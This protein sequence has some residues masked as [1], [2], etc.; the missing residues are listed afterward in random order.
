MNGFCVDSRCLTLSNFVTP[1][2]RPLLPPQQSLEDGAGIFS[3]IWLSY[4]SP[5][6]RQGAQKPLTPLDLGGPSAQDRA[7]NCHAKV[8]EAYNAQPDDKKSIA[9]AVVA[10]F[11]V[12]RFLYALF[13][14]V[15][16]AALQFLP[17]LI[18][19][20]LIKYFQA[21]PKVAT[22]VDPW[23]EVFAMFLI[24]TLVTLLQARHNVIMCHMSVYVRTA[25]SIMI[26]EKILKISSAG[27]AKTSTGAIVNMMSNDTTQVQR[28]IQFLGF[29]TTA[30]FQVAF[31]LYLIYQEVG[32]ATFAGVGFLL[33]LI[34]INI[35]VFILVGKNRRATLKE[36]DNRVKLVSEILSGIRII[37]FY[38]WE[39]PFRKT[40][41]EV[42][43]QELFFLTRLAYISAVGFSMIML[44]TPIILPIVVFAVY[45]ATSSEP[46]DAAK[47]FTTVALFNIM[48]FPFAFMPMGFLQY[49]QAKIAMGRID[50]LLKLPELA[51]Y[52]VC[53]ETGEGG[54]QEIVIEN[55]SFGWGVA[56]KKEGEDEEEEQGKGRRGGRR[57]KKGKG[58][59]DEQEKEPSAVVTPND[60]DGD[61]DIELENITLLDAKTTTLSD[62]NL[63]IDRGEL[64]GVVGS[65]GSGK[66]RWTR[67]E[68]HYALTNPLTQP[69]PPLARRA[70]LPP[71]LHPRRHGAHERGL[72]G[73]PATQELRELAQLHQL[74]RPDPLGRQRHPKGQHSFRKGLRRG[75]V[76]R[77]RSGLRPHRRSRRTP[78]RGP[79]RDWGERNQ[80]LRRAEGESL[81]G[82]RSL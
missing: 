77:C 81:T 27:R 9:K 33:A 23:L 57:G 70:V 74:L 37:K 19:N 45:T 24:P 3:T 63:S 42:R 5:L 10:S 44:S 47:A 12:G 68:F 14:Y 38:A 67:S 82:P 53:G 1:P 50:F 48:R 31:S 66:V 52:I 69:S 78:R 8:M 29:V 41:E 55:A 56:E 2:L 25:V 13:L 51:D 59:N 20:D 61:G 49:I 73:P 28:F 30:P 65:V 4:L 46:L 35:C 79:Y 6:L 62:I 22:V 71:Q 36:S 80:P 39:S 32:V 34:P 54:P 21:Y 7:E 17:V 40:V 75:K 16:S 64:Y 11:G 18:L 15:V 60:G 26:Y 43:K 72:Q 76:L 58:K